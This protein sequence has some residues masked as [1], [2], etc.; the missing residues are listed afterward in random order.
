MCPVTVLPLAR[1]GTVVS[2][3]C[4]RSAARTW[5][6]DQRMQR[7]QHRRAGA[8]LVGQRRHAQIDALAGV[9]LALP[10]QRLMLAELLEQDHGQQVRAGEAARRHM[11][12][13]RRLGD[14]LAVPAREL[15][16]HRLDHLPLARDH[17]QRLGDVLAELRQLRR[18]AAGTALR[19]GD[20]DAL[21]RQMLGERLAR[22]PLALER[23]DRL[24]LRRRLLGRQF[25]LGRGR[26]QL[27]ELQLHLL[28]Q[29]RLALRA[30]AVKLAPQLLDLQLEMGDQRFGAGQ[31]RLGIGRF[32]LGDSPQRPRPARAR[33]AP[34]GS[35][36]ARR[37]DRMG[38]IQN[39]DVTRR[40]NHIR[41]QSASQNRHPT[42]VGRQVSCGWRQSIPDSR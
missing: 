32:G 3:P 28:Q 9:A 23:L 1:I 42:E 15:L 34:R 11:E 31:V 33:R 19:R 36:H 27:F 26:L 29:P 7:L 8:D 2:S 18:A 21:A 37:Q 41:Q 6:L 20:H 39:V 30:A 5:R 12:R 13:R 24:R 22:R 25:V 35:S 17:L 10:V 16:A 40:W 14:R 4:S 38:A